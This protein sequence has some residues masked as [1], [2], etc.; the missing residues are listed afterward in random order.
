M[1]SYVYAHPSSLTQCFQF[2]A[3]ESQEK[4]LGRSAL[5]SEGNA[6]PAEQ[7]GEQ[8]RGLAGAQGDPCC[9]SALVLPRRFSKLVGT[10]SALSVPGAGQGTGWFG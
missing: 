2:L 9:A 1:C 4:H 10:G 5:W 6:E 7:F 3:E 8:G